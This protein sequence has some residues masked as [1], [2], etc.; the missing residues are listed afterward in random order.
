MV[1]WFKAM[2]EDNATT[3]LSQ[4]RE[5][6][7][8]FDMDRARGITC[9]TLLISGENSP[10]RFT[11]IQDRPAQDLPQSK[12]AVLTLPSHGII[13]ANPPAFPPSARV[14]ITDRPYRG[15][16]TPPPHFCGT[17]GT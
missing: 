5:R 8:Y 17:R 4:I 3:L 1:G 10:E 7:G 16:P 11:R 15:C 6:N 14:L 9:P 2:V 13:L 12:R